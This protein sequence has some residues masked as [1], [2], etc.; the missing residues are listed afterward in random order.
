MEQT[1]II[2]WNKQWYK[3]GHRWNKDTKK[4]YTKIQN[5]KKENTSVEI[6]NNKNRFSESECKYDALINNEFSD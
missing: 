6:N 3:C 4:K 2:K 5:K 1:Q